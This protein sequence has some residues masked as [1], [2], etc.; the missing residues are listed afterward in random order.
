MMEQD[1]V[2]RAEP[3]PAGSVITAIEPQE[4]H[5]DRRSI[6]VDGEFALGVH[7][8]V[9]LA[10]GLAVGQH[11]DPERLTEIAKAEAFRKAKE[12]AL[13]LLSY[14]QRTRK[15]IQD[16][17][18]SRGYDDDTI[19]AVLAQLAETGLVDDAAFA[20]AWANWRRHSRPAGRTLL[21]WELKAKG[22][23]SEIVEDVL[24]RLGPDQEREGALTAARHKL[25]QSAARDPQAAKR[26]LADFLRRRGF[27]W[28]AIRY[29]LNTLAEEGQWEPMDP[30][31]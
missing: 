16:K 29:V 30:D 10:L 31:G 14:R 3:A 28:D 27:D 17:L 18:R 19:S 21:K 2:G 13:R 22:V 12:Y 9:V 6:F 8:E 15:E 7:A 24:S 4:R 5:P 1:A 23:P 26:T 25:R 11:V 20:D